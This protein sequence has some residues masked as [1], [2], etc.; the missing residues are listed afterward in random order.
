MSVTVPPLPARTTVVNLTGKVAIVTGAAG[1]IGLGISRGLAEAGATVI[2]ADRDLASAKR[3]VRLIDAS[4]Q[5]ESRHVDVTD[6]ASVEALVAATAG[7]HGRVDILINNAATATDA[8]V[9]ETSVAEW[10][11]V[12]DVNLTGP[13]L[14]SRAVIPHMQAQ[15]GGRIVN[16]GSVASKRISLTHGASYTAAKEG[17]VGFTR[18]LAYEVA[19]RG[20]TANVVCPGATLTAEIADRWTPETLASRERAMPRGRVAQPEDIMRVVLFLVSDLADLVCGQAIDVDAGAL[21]GWQ[22]TETYFHQRRAHA[23]TR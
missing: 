8:I 19:G 2:L 3:A 16:I 5:V 10:R 4:G 9:E 14:C 1:G 21:L 20:I 23:A 13:F 18:H 12:L 11:T 6:E 7:R 22:D 17:L 15:G